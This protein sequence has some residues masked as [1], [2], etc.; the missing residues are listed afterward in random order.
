M[1]TNFYAILPIHKRSIDVV[2]GA[3]YTLEGLLKKLEKGNDVWDNIKE[4]SNV[5]AEGIKNIDEQRKIHLGKRSAGWSFLWDANKLKYYKPSLKSIHKWIVD[6]NAIIKDEYGEEFSWDEFIN[7]EIGKC[8]Y[9]SKAIRSIEELPDDMNPDTVKYIK[10]NYFDKNLPYFQYCS[11]RSYHIMHPN[12]PTYYYDNISIP[13]F[14][15]YAK[16]RFVDF[17]FS[18]FQSKDGLRFAIYTNFS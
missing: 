9:T 6:N 16:N 13:D 12:E 11:H 14:T 2:E 8:L 5:L 17:E 18:E 15:P 7:D 1:G 10:E 4:F 3:V